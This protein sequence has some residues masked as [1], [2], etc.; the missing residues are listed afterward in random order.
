MENTIWVQIE[1]TKA[2]DSVWSFKGEM[3]QRDFKAITDN[4]RSNGYFKLDKVYWISSSYDDCGNEKGGTLYQYGQENLR[5]FRGE[6]YLR[7]EH[8]VSIAPIDAELDLESFKAAQQKH[9][10]VVTPIRN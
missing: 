5:A 2:N 7:I 8:L 9:L 3:S 6:L 10:S 4:R 1:T